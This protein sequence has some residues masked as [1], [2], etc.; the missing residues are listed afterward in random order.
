MRHDAPFVVRR[1]APLI[2]RHEG[3]RRRGVAGKAYTLEHAME[4]ASEPGRRR[5][6]LQAT[7]EREG[8][9]PGSWQAREILELERIATWIDHVRAPAFVARRGAP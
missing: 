4:I 2:G 1:L 3:R 8:L 5:R 9:G 6:A 7:V